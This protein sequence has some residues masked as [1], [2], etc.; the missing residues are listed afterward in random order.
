MADNVIKCLSFSCQYIENEK[1]QLHRFP[2]TAAATGS[3]M[4]TDGRIGPC[5]K[6]PCMQ[7][8]SFATDG[9]YKR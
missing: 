4:L 2:K 3:L 9:Q 1:I 8:S 7:L 5:V 6:F